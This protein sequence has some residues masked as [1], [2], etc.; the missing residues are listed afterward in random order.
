MS[1]TQSIINTEET[2]NDLQ[3]TSIA[4][5]LQ[6]SPCLMT[7]TFLLLENISTAV[8][9]LR[10]AA[11]AGEYISLGCY[12]SYLHLKRKLFTITWHV[13]W[14]TSHLPEQTFHSPFNW[15]D[16]KGIY[17]Q[18]LAFRWTCLQTIACFT[19]F[20]LSPALLLWEN[21]SVARDM[22]DYFRALNAHEKSSIFLNFSISLLWLTTNIEVSEGFL[23]EC[24]KAWFISFSCPECFQGKFV[25][26]VC[27]K[28]QQGNA[29]SVNML[30]INWQSGL[31]LV[32][33][34]ETRQFACAPISLKCLLSREVRKKHH[35]P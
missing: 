32:A 29:A 8:M 2:E 26:S 20:Q 34:S 4:I 31:A 12:W 25:A 18:A 24:S 1:K 30:Y 27:N 6:S 22:S 7:Q 14:R 11:C 13:S 28:I 23:G 35:C 21:D 9:V 5:S 15:C 19:Q 10:D 16:F 33:I 17:I 3:S